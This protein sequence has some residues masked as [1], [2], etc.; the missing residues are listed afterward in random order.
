MSLIQNLTMF[1][2]MIFGFSGFA[3]LMFLPALL[4]LRRPKDAGPRIIMDDIAFLMLPG[5]EMAQ[6]GKMEE[7]I[8]SNRTIASKIMDITCFLPNLEA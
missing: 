7:E 6:M 2:S 8:E 5:F 4:E 1:I 3:F